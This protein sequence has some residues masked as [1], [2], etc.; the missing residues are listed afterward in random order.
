MTTGPGQPGLLPAGGGA[1]ESDHAL[2]ARVVRRSPGALESI[3]DRY[4]GKVHAACL[5]VT[6]DPGD[7]EE[8]LGDVFWEFWSHPERYDAARSAL[9]TYLV[10]LARSRAVDRARRHGRRARIADASEDRIRE[11]V[12]ASQGA[13]LADQRAILDERSVM[14]TEALA[15]LDDAQQAALE[16]SYFDGL[17]HAE[18]AE[19]TGLPLGT[20][21][22][23][24]RQGLL[25]MRR[26]LSGRHGGDP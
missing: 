12:H 14:V 24:I 8:L 13:D 10:V 2:V 1:G 3:Y 9:G 15:A 6:R 18:I 11:S 23:R 16:M 5:R 25:H 4:S 22:G 26:F 21:K 17:S 19:R 20:V 7:A